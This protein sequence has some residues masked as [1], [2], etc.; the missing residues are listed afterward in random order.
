MKV[1]PWS[2][3][4]NL[5]SSYPPILSVPQTP[6]FSGSRNL[7]QAILS[8]STTVPTLS[9]SRGMYFLRETLSDPVSAPTASCTPPDTL[10]HSS[11]Y[12]FSTPFRQA[13][14][15]SLGFQ[16]E[17]NQARSLMRGNYLPRG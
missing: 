6:G 11:D 12:L 16:E 9:V 8:A 14:S 17:Q 2:S 3:F 1:N 15:Q 10:I 7:P 13:L 4:L 5:S